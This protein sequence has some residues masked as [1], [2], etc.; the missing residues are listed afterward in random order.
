MYKTFRNTSSINFD[1]LVGTY[2]CHLDKESENLNTTVG[3]YIT[4]CNYIYKVLKLTDN[5]IIVE[6]NFYE[7]LKNTKIKKDT[8]YNDF[9]NG[10]YVICN[11]RPVSGVE[12]GEYPVEV[13][14]YN[15]ES[16][17]D[18]SKSFTT[19]EINQ[20]LTREF[21]NKNKSYNDVKNCIDTLCNLIMKKFF[22]YN[23]IS[24]SYFNETN[25]LHVGL[26]IETGKKYLNRFG[27][28]K[29]KTYK[30]KITSIEF[31]PIEGKFYY[32]GL[33]GYVWTDLQNLIVKYLQ[34]NHDY[35]L[36]L[37]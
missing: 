28:I 14:N 29:L 18:L 1:S 35:I 16:N 33:E 23:N 8:F 12:V 11:T 5:F 22:N 34:D 17:V 7:Q 27:Q 31:T 24:R 19:D 10:R 20:L 36:Q 26:S 37:K 21:L 32:R 9:F 15:F 13:P 4:N 2:L 25:S 3:K 30:G 6:S